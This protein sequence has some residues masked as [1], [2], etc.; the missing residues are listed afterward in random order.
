MDD[1][2]SQSKNQENILWLHK[3]FANSC[4]YSVCFKNY[5]LVEEKQLTLIG[6]PNYK[7]RISS[8]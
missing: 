1:Y 8:V 2:Q 7:I 4:G 6:A 5:V 3:Y